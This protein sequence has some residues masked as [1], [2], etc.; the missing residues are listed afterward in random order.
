[1]SLKKLEVGSQKPEDQAHDHT[2][3]LK[4]L[5]ASLA[6]ALALASLLAVSVTVANAPAASEQTSSSTLLATAD[7]VFQE[8]SRNTSLPIRAALKSELL[9]RAQVEKF[10]TGKIRE[11]I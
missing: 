2:L 9:S 1:M 8:M 5:C 6:V 11:G 10:M 7:Q 4:L 3:T